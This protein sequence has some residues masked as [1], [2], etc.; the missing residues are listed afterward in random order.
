M[1]LI[2]L[3][4]VSHSPCH[5]QGTSFALLALPCIEVRTASSGVP[6]LIPLPSRGACSSAVPAF[7]Q[8]I[9]AIR[10]TVSPSA[11]LENNLPS[12]EGL[13]FCIFCFFRVFGGFFALLFELVFDFGGLVVSVF[14]DDGG[15]EELTREIS[16]L[17][18]RPITSAGD[19]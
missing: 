3:S 15:A 7:S 13:I 14:L 17:D 1:L 2:I 11:A 12:P 5:T 4:M 9:T 10:P 8:R 6:E 19:N 16:L 18:L